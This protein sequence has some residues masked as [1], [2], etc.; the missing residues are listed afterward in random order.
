MSVENVW[1][2]FKQEIKNI[3]LSFDHFKD[4]FLYEKIVESNSAF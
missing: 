4:T 2:N 1:Q 3:G